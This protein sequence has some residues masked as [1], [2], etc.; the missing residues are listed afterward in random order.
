M[1]INVDGE[2]RKFKSVWFE[3]NEVVLI[4]QRN[5]PEKLEFFRAKNSDD[6]AYAIK[7]MVVR[8]APAIGV[9]AA[10]GLHWQK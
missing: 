2:D 10:Y 3:N 8:G 6:I 7:H 1:K 4:E 9:T 5:L